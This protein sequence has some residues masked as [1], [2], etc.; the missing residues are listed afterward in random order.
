MVDESGHVEGFVTA[1]DIISVFSPPCMDS[2]IDGGSFFSTALE[3]AGC[4]V[5]GG[6]LIE[7]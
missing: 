5:E 1:R 3:Q 6:V 7:N 2:R 4:H